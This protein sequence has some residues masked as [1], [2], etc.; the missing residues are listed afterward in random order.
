MRKLFRVEDSTANKVSYYHLAFFLMA[1]PFDFFYSELILVSFAVHNLIHVKKENLK[2]IFS[3][4]VLLMISLFLLGAIAISYSPDKQEGLN[5]TTRQLAILLFPVLLAITGLDLEKY[6]MNLLLIFGFTCVGTVLYLYAEAVRTILYFGLKASSL[7]TTPFM[8]HNFSQPIGIHATYLS[9]YAAFSLL[10]FLYLLITQKKSPVTVF[11]VFCAVVLFAGL[12]Q[13]SSRAVVIA[14]LM[15]INFG[16]TFFLFSGKRRWTFFLITT[17]LSATTVAIIWNVDSFKT[18]YVS[19]LKTD[20]TNNATI[21]EN[22]EPRLARWDAIT[23]IIKG[24]PLIGYGTGAEKKLLKE[25]Y[26]EKQLYIS[27]LNEFNTHNEYLGILVKTGLVGLLL[28]LYI[29]YTG[30]AAAIRRKDLLFLSFMILVSV[31]ALSENVIELNK[32]IFF[33]AFFLSFFLG[34][35]SPAA[36][37]TGPSLPAGN[38]V[39]LKS[40]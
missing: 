21:V 11:Y 28:F 35:V 10:V 15:V 6:R 36:A 33:Y 23:E 3:R 13:L 12:I 17:L 30:F 14:F 4:P 24:S 38:P 5:V 39:L 19:E 1:L 25:K 29:L 9:M 20:L 27:Y 2:N 16:F 40:V 7:F 8:N 18:R 31:V 26:Y 22:F 34:R 32:G 37:L